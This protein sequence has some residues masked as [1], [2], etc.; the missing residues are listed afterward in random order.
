MKNNK[1]KIIAGVIV[2]VL[3][4]GLA[5]YFYFNSRE[6]LGELG[7]PKVTDLSSASST[8]AT[9]VASSTAPIAEGS[10]YS[11]LGNLSYGLRDPKTKLTNGYYL[12]KFEDCGGASCQGV[13]YYSHMRLESN[14][15]E[16]DLNGDGTKDAAIIMSSV[17]TSSPSIAGIVYTTQVL[18]ALVNEGGVYKNVAAIE[19]TDDL[20]AKTTAIKDVK[21]KD[22]VIYATV[23]KNPGSTD[24][25]FPTATEVVKLVL[26]SDIA[27]GL[28][29]LH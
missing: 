12:G 29:I 3:V 25:K 23:I 5:A 22:G 2:L 21:I 20:S 26:N 28:G 1:N 4:I 11:V 24:S 15:A 14:I 13:T 19:L 10:I 6:N 27:G 16:G 8:F 9:S 17:T 18:A 7:K